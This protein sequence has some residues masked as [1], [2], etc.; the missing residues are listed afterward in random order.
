MQDIKIEDVILELKNDK[1]FSAIFILGEKSF[2]IHLGMLQQ[3]RN[4]PQSLVFLSLRREFKDCHIS[5]YLLVLLFLLFVCFSIVFVLF[6]SCHL[7]HK[8]CT[9]IRFL[10]GHFIVIYLSTIINMILI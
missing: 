2:Q 8:Q 10:T 9:E 6:S 3:C 7:V 1:D 4:F 5:F